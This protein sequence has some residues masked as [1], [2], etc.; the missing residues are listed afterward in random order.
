[1]LAG[2]ENRTWA[3]TTPTTVCGNPFNRISRPMSVGSPP[4]RVRH[5][6]S[7]IT[8][9]LVPCR[10][11]SGRNVRPATGTT[12]ST[13]KNLVETLWRSTLSTVPSGASSNGPPPSPSVMAAIASN[14]RF[15]S[16]QSRRLTRP[17][18]DRAFVPVR[19]QIITRRSGSAYGRERIS[20]ASAS[21]N[22]AL[23]A[24]MP[25]A[26]VSAAT[27]VNAGDPFS[28]RIANLTSVRNSSN[29]RRRQRNVLSQSMLPHL[30]VLA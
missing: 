22:I 3:G 7:L 21:E 18:D 1:M 9:T 24:P 29:H 25:S 8:T 30:L 15:R 23:L 14:E 4:K 13:S 17:A 28:C 5:N 27:S 16:S 2:R 11:S 26:S 6:C 20:V 19:S 10:S 12:P